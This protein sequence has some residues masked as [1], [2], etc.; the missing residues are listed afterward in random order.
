MERASRPLL[1]Q[2]GGIARRRADVRSVEEEIGHLLLCQSE[3]GHGITSKICLGCIFS[4][5]TIGGF[6]GVGYFIIS[7]C[8]KIQNF[9]LCLEGRIDHTF[10]AAKFSFD[11][12]Q[13]HCS[14]V[15]KPL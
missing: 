13:E 8:Q 4:K 15:I 6:G 1:F 5:I 10:N 11:P 9:Y 7:I 2:E 3:V 14:I 12:L